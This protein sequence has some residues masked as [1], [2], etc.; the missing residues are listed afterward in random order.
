[1]PRTQFQTFLEELFSGFGPIELR[2]VFGFQGIYRGEIMFGLLADE[3]VFLK[4]GDSNR[5]AFASEGAKP[6]HYHLRGK[7]VAL[8]YYELPPRLYDDPEEA[9]EWARKAYEVAVQSPTARRKSR[10]G[11]TARKPRSK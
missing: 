3:R 8:S 6:L 9:A 7:D 5:A 2:A 11:V 1:M 4:T 10:K